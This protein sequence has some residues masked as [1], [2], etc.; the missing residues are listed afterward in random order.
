MIENKADQ[1]QVATDE[2]IGIN[3]VADNYDAEGNAPEP[4]QDDELESYTKGVSR[5]IN[6]LNEKNRQAE[7]RAQQL[8]QLALQKE[9]ELQQYRQYTQQM[10]NSMLQKEAEALQAKESQ[11]DDIYK[12][13][14]EA[15]DAELM[16]KA[17]GLKNDLAIQKEK[18]RVAAQR[19]DAEAQQQMAY[20]QQMQGQNMQQQGMDDQGQWQNYE[21]DGEAEEEPTEE[22]EG[23]HQQNQWYGDESD[24][25]NKEATQFA[26][27]THFNLINEGYEADSD[28]YYEALD[29]RVERAYPHTKSAQAYVPSVSSAEENRQQ[30]AVQRVASTQ[31]TGRQQTR[32]SKKGDVH[33]SQSELERLRGLKPHNM[34]EQAW[35]QRV[36]QEKQKKL[37][38]GVR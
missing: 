10:G 16:A 26:Y 18:V 20:E 14:V 33:F 27:Y 11:V 13:A 30:P 19:Q 6:K 2:E 37:N 25:Q 31:H 4:S 21:D 23:W 32:G 17:T 7:A 22:A 35:L 5:R 36:A 9:Q 34:S 15:N 29:S 38:Q 28:E 3:V 8:E 1:G 24:P 12:K